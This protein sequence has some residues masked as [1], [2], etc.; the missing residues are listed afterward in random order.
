MTK[1]KNYE[2]LPHLQSSFKE[3]VRETKRI[4]VHSRKSDKKGL[5]GKFETI[6]R[7]FRSFAFLIAIAPMIVIYLLSFGIA[8]T[9]GVAI[10]TS[11]YEWTASSALLLRAFCVGMGI[12]ISYFIFG[13]SLVFL[14]PFF[15]WVLRLNSKIKSNWRGSWFSIETLP[16]YYHNALTQM[17]RYT[18]LDFITPTP[19]NIL[20]FKMMG[21]K[22]GR[23]VMINT[24]NISD[25][26]LITLEDNV[27][28][29]GSA[30]I[31]G[32]YAQGG[33]LI[34]S[35]VVI[36]QGATIG[37]KASIMGDV[38]IGEKVTVKPHSVILPKSR[39]SKGDQL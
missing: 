25:P 31:F 23:G 13:I 32:H 6:I 3:N 30:T 28:I 29:G 14:A 26:C 8:L 34:L 22:V 5:R 16:W 11:L 39:I 36:K 2:D 19:L 1:N 35:P 33:F 10:V 24:S 18:F 20:F 4:D 21:M 12:G 15:N 17:V 37:L 38:I 27:T 9:P 7:S